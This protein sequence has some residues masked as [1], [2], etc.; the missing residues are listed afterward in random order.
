MTN[1]PNNLILD[2][3]ETTILT[4]SDILTFSSDPSFYVNPVK[5]FYGNIAVYS[6]LFE[7]EQRYPH[8]IWDTPTELTDRLLWIIGMK[9]TVNEL[10]MDHPI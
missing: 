10:L 2:I 8:I 5:T 9:S 3:R 4:L 1:A 6:T 7:L